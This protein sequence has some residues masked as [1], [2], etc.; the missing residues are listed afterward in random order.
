M[1]PHWSVMAALGVV[2]VTFGIPAVASSAA[3]D[4]QLAGQRI[5]WP[6]DGLTVSRSMRAAITRGEVGSVI[7][8][9]RNAPTARALR[10]LTAQL[11]AVP[12]PIGLDEPLLVMVDQ[13][14]GYVKR[15]PQIPPTMSP[16]MM[17]LRLSPAAIRDQGLAT[18]RALLGLGVNTNLAPLCDV[19]TRGGDLER[20]DRAFGVTV[21]GVSTDCA[22]FA[23]GLG[24]A[25]VIASPKHFP[26]FGR[27][28]INTDDA[29]VRVT[30]TRATIT[31][32]LA[33]FRRVVMAG[34]PMV[35]VSSIIF[36]AFAPRPALLSPYVIKRLLRGELGFRG[37]TITDAID[38]PALWPW[39]GTAGAS[40]AA[41]VAGM[42]LIIV[43]SREAE[44][45]TG[46]RA[47]AASLRSGR[48]ARADAHASLARVL[49]L[50]ATLP[51]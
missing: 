45:L 17:G 46:A 14:G 23:Q 34:A 30:A 26:G 22:A 9:S 50:R 44:A 15:I 38:T 11:Q 42:D 24:D 2:A 1:S 21:S 25:G 33:P 7:L 51:G 36:T 35:M 49:D 37:V 12:R 48:L 41:A 47:V 16:E 20:D 3:T 27:A 40:G 8:F 18:G 28:R 6:V 5:T 29:P 10:R 19:A 32:E 13:E 39:G 4:A 43:A 31:A